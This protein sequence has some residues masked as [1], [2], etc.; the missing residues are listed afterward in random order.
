MRN[1]IAIDYGTKRHGIAA[2]DPLGIS[3]RP[4]P[5]VPAEP[6]SKALQAILGVISDRGARLVLVG[7]PLN[8]DGSEGPAARSVRGF[9]A[10]LKDKLP[11]GVAIEFWDERLTTDDAEKTLLERGL[12]HRER[13]QVI[14]SISAA[15][16]LKSWL[17][18]S[19]GPAANEDDNAR[20]LPP[21]E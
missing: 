17:D 14:D 12:S 16:L 9:A 2:C 10:D 8:M 18:E 7:L 4:L 1:V 15:I 3:V 20:R 11:P 21:L 6:R 5:F 13:K 19:A